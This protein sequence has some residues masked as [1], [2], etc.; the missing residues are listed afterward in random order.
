LPE[1]RMQFV[2]AKAGIDNETRQ[3]FEEL[4]ECPSRNC[5]HIVAIPIQ[6]GRTL[7][8]LGFHFDIAQKWLREHGQKC[9]PKLLN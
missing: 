2:G 3:R 4:H 1:N 9:V 6:P 5:T 7:R 8:R